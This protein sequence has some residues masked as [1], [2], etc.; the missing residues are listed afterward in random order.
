M[1]PLLSLLASVEAAQQPDRKLDAHIVVALDLRPD[2]LNGRPGKMW[3]DISAHVGPVVRFHEDG[4]G[5][6]PSSG[7]P[8][9]GDFPEY[10]AS[11]DSTL[12]LVERMLPEWSRQTTMH[13]KH[14]DE[15]TTYYVVLYL[16]DYNN[17]NSIAKKVEA[18]NEG[19]IST[20]ALVTI[21]ALLRAM[22]GKT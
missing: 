11:I 4:I 1:T 9:I 7:E 19:R 13:P 5:K 6:R 16:I 3:V 2:W 20:E 21:A 15:P 14:G 10:T 18:D 22:E 8:P 17:S 12:A